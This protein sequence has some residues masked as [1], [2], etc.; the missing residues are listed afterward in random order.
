MEC[1]LAPVI[2]SWI[3]RKELKLLEAFAQKSSTAT[4]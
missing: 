1:I 3:Y 2:N 4:V